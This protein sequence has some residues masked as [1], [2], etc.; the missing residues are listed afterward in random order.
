MKDVANENDFPVGAKVDIPWGGQCG[1]D[2]AAYSKNNLGFRPDKT[3]GPCLGVDYP[4][5]PEVPAAR[6]FL[7][8]SAEYRWL[9]GRIESE[10]RTDPVLSTDRT[11]R[12]HL[13]DVVG[14]QRVLTLEMDWHL[15][16][17]LAEQFDDPSNVELGQVLCCS[18]L[19]DKAYV[20]T[21]LEVCVSHEPLWRISICKMSTSDAV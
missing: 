3:F 20:T 19:A 5:I 6:K 2:E 14:N 21:C 15:T 4:A 1:V 16:S 18:G 11:I 10:A 9:L 7:V 12:Q 17:F 13:A 8:Q